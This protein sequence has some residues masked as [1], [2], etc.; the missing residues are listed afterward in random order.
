MGSPS[1]GC[2]TPP[3]QSATRSMSSSRGSWGTVDAPKA[4]ASRRWAS[5]RATTITSTV[6]CKR[7]QDGD[8]ALAER[9]GAIDEHLASRLRWMAGDRV[10]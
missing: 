8:G 5:N 6:G 4:S 2:S 10:E 3:D 1:A 7:P 9:A